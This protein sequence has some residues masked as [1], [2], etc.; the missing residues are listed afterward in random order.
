MVYLLVEAHVNEHGGDAV[1][2]VVPKEFM[3]LFCESAW[4]MGAQAM[5]GVLSMMH[6]PAPTPVGND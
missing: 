2:G 6:S 4:Q 1:T 3:G 5:G